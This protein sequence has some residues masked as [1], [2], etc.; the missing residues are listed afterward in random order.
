MADVHKR[1]E[2]EERLKKG[3]TGITTVAARGNVNDKW[4]V[5]EAGT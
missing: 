4:E 1:N 5:K 3:R 2:N